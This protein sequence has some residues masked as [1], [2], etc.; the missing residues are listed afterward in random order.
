MFFTV[1]CKGLCS[2]SQ[3]C[4]KIIEKLYDL[5]SEHLKSCT[6]KKIALDYQN[7]LINALGIVANNLAGHFIMCVVYMHLAP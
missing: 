2:N 7:S 3:N 6:T 1:A 4:F 5:I